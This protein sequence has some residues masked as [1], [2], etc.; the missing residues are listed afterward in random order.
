MTG[1]RLLLV[2]LLLITVAQAKDWAAHYAE[3]VAEFQA[4]NAKL[5]ASKRRVVLVGDSLT[6]GWRWS[7]RVS[8]FLPTIGDRVLN[9]GISA[10]GVGAGAA[11][12]LKRRLDA[13]IYDCQ[14]GHVVLLLGVNDLGRDGRG[15]AGAARVYEELVRQVRERLPRVPLILVTLAP[16]RG[17]YAALNPHVLAF[18]EHVRRIARETKCTLLDLHPLLVDGEGQ[19]PEAMAT[20][21]GLH[22]TDAVYE[23]LGRELERLVR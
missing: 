14:P 10:D 5:E 9:R 16:A 2:S 12:G 18:N 4:E 8:K 22:W 11:R 23:V 17:E 13:S 21:D 3:R 1:P 19:L 20:K 15:V 7:R 6:E